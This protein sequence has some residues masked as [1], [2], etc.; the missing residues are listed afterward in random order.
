MEVIAAKITTKGQVTIPK[1]IRDAL[2]SDVV[3]FE[4][5]DG[6]VTLRPVKSVAGGLSDYAKEYVPLEKVRE[7]VWKGVADD[8]VDKKNDG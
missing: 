8:R 5:L 1:K 4:V 2:G 3:E 7:T 6:G